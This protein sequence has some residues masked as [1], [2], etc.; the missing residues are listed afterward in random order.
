MMYHDIAILF[1]SNTV[2]FDFPHCTK[3]CLATAK[4]CV[5]PGKTPGPIHRIRA[6]AFLRKSNKP[7]A[8][9]AALSQY[10]IK[11]ALEE[12]RSREDWR[13]R[14]PVVYYRF[15]KIFD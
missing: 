11:N 14:E 15:F 2:T 7:G 8:T 13:T 12:N 6:V 3:E 9:R 1:S 4:P 10:E 5:T